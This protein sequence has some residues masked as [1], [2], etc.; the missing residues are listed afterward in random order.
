FRAS[1]R[2]RWLS[3]RRT[4]SGTSR[5]N[6]PTSAMRCRKP[7]RFSAARDYGCGICACRTC[8]WKTSSLPSRGGGCVTEHAGTR[9]PPR[10]PRRPIL[11]TGDLGRAAVLLTIP[12]AAL[13]AGLSMLHLYAVGLV[14]GVFT[15]F[16]DV[17]YQA[18]LPALVDRR[19]LVEGNSKLEATRSL[20]NL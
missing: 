17:A 2:S 1:G 7:F 4:A 19:Q 3:S 16:F 6:W 20:A 5:S 11:I 15:V 12:V 13:T 9:Q 14:V 18:Y 10:G 8:H